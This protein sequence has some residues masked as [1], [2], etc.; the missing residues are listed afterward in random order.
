QFLDCVVN[1]TLIPKLLNIQIGKKAPQIYLS[2]VQQKTNSQLASCLPCHLIHTEMISEPTWNECFK[3][4]LEERA[5][6]IFT[7]IQRYA[8]AP[9]GDMV[10][11]HSAQAET[12]EYSTSDGRDRL[13]DM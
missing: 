11:K 2:E 7:L 12:I 6:N 10:S 5:K 13:K 9:A 8:I 3:L 1:R 4:F